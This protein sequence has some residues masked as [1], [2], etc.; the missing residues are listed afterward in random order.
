MSE[1]EI[2]VKTDYEPTVKEEVEFNISTVANPKTRRTRAKNTVNDLVE[3]VENG[4]PSGKIHKAYKNNDTVKEFASNTA[5]L[6]AESSRRI[7]SEMDKQENEMM[8]ELVN[9]VYK[10]TVKVDDS[11]SDLDN[12]MNSLRLF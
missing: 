8:N 7:L 1:E 3:I 4:K 6:M 12:V 2:E 5:D 10:P 11:G 9:R